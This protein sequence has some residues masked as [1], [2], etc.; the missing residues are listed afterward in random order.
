MEWHH[1]SIGL[2]T[3][4]WRRQMHV[5]SQNAPRLLVSDTVHASR[6]RYHGVVRLISRTVDVGFAKAYSIGTLYCFQATQLF[7]KKENIVLTLEPVHALAA[8]SWEEKETQKRSEKK[9]AG[10]LCEPQA[11]NF[12]K[13][14]QVCQGWEIKLFLFHLHFCLKTF[15]YF[16]RFNYSRSAFHSH[17]TI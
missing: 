12:Q 10:R 14:K 11:W 4:S 3:L 1:R 17:N 16:S 6:L 5:G 15:F 8:V 9:I 7:F 13:I 2:L